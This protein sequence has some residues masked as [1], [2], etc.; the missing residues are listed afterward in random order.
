MAAIPPDY[1]ADP[2]RW[3]SHDR[4]WL[5]DGDAHELAAARI[6]AEHRSPVLDLGCGDGRLAELLPSTVTCFG[7]D[8]SVRQLASSRTPVVRAGACQLPWRAGTFGAVAALWMLYHLDQPVEAL[9]EGYRVLR[10][11]GMF[12]AATAARTNDP[13][14]TGGYPATTFDAEDAPELVATV[15]G[16]ELEVIRWDGPLVVLPTRDAIRRYC[17]SHGLPAERAGE[18]EAPLTLTKRGCLVLAIKR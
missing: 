16:D 14:L 3:L 8:S 15:F 12:L 10:P 13:E 7:V 2:Q 5:V 4:S 17:R 1:D 11:G 6:E 9:R 18:V